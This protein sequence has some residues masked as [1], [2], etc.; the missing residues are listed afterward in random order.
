MSE[1]KPQKFEGPLAAQPTAQGLIAYYDAIYHD[2]GMK[3]PPHLK[4]VCPG[5]MDD[6]IQKLM[7]IVGPGSGKSQLLSVAYSSHRIGLD[8]TQTIIGISGGEA[9]MQGFLHSVMEIVEWS[10]QYR[11]IF[12]KVRPD[13]VAGWSTERGIFVKG[14]VAGDPD[15]SYWCCGLDS[16]ALVGKHCRTQ[17]CDDLHNKENS[18]S[19]E[20]CEK[21]IGRYYDTLLGR[22][23]PRGCKYIIAGRRWHENDIYGH[24]RDTGEWVVLELPAE[25][26]GS[27]D[28]WYD[29]TI[30]DGMTCCYNDGSLGG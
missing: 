23:D 2:R 9:L 22:A 19:I 7:L 6:R 27:H 8:P 1:T 28:L 29:V 3:M 24:L 17:I 14:R 11:S 15:A 5:L 13:K 26:T 18:A 20:Q 25:R 21:V 10:P 12:P 4:P 16:Q 30:P